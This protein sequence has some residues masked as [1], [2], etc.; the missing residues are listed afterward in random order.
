[1]RTVILAAFAITT[2]MTPMPWCVAGVHI[3]QGALDHMAQ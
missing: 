2:F 1:M 3:V